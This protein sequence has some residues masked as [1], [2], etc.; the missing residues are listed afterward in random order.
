[1]CDCAYRCEYLCVYVCVVCMYVF[2]GARLCKC[3][4][5]SVN[6]LACACTFVCHVNA[7]VILTGTLP[8]FFCPPERSGNDRE[9]VAFRSRVQNENETS[10]KTSVA[11][12]SFERWHCR[13]FLLNNIFHCLGKNHQLNFAF[14]KVLR[15]DLKLIYKYII[16]KYI[17]HIWI[18]CYRFL[19]IF[20]DIFHFFYQKHNNYCFKSICYK[21]CIIFYEFCSKWLREKIVIL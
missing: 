6:V 5:G 11:K 18:L 8:V 19:K 12:G 21:I 16:Y 13:L 4:R 1:M 15:D 14:K 3:T 17:V 9:T 20:H 2:V 7:P 10:L